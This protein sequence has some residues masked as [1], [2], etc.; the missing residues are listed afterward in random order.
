M[1]AALLLE[2]RC[3]MTCARRD[4]TPGVRIPLNERPA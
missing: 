2:R 1:S 3:R 4:T